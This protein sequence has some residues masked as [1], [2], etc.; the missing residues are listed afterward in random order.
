M[1]TSDIVFPMV[2]G[3]PEV[4]V[5]IS[6]PSAPE[7]NVIFPLASI[8]IF[9]LPK[10]LFVAEIVNVLS[11]EELAVNVK[12]ESFLPSRDNLFV[13]MLTSLPETAVLILTLLLAPLVLILTV[14]ELPL[15]VTP[16]APSSV[17][18]P[19]VVV[20]LE[21]SPASNLIP[22]PVALISTIPDVVIST[23]EAFPAILTPPA[24]S[25]VSAPEVVVKLEASPASNL[26]PA[27]VALISTIPDVVIST[28]EA[29]PAI[30]TP[31]APL[32]V[33][34]PEEV[35]KLE[36]APASNVIPAPV[37]LISTVPDVVISTSA[38]FPAILTP[39]LPSSVNAPEEVVNLEA[40]PASIF[41][42]L[43]ASISMSSAPERVSLP[44]EVVKLEAP[45]ASI[46]TPPVPALI[47]TKTEFNSISVV[48]FIA[49]PNLISDATAS[50]PI[51]ISLLAG[52]FIVIP[53]VPSKLKT[54]DE[55]VKLDP[56]PAI[57]SVPPVP[58]VS[59]NLLFAVILKS[60]VAVEEIVALFVLAFPSN[61]KSPLKAVVS[62]VISIC[63]FVVF[64]IFSVFP[65]VISLPVTVKSPFKTMFLKRAS[66]T[67]PEYTLLLFEA[68]GINVNSLL[69]LSLP[70][71]PRFEVVPSKYLKAIPLS[72]LSVAL[73]D[74]I[75]K[76]GSETVTPPPPP[77]LFV[78]V[79]LPHVKVP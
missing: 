71:K 65:N 13:S 37:E 47:S 20:K 36:A 23:S 42:P 16:P 69:S 53:S 63:P 45:P 27:P 21:A 43:E 15:I 75:I 5:A 1:I 79:K 12:L 19:E 39:P 64:S 50:S 78:I 61:V 3:T 56:P 17:N 8:S 46:V 66:P 59:C 67:V 4:P 30:L 9:A 14:L 74:P 26:I 35:V 22:A 40:A 31:P 51:N 72:W 33:N 10:E 32:S 60:L 18:A 7:S 25:S 57:I 34:A 11:L 73:S 49:F 70:K 58:A 62:A 6:I 44:E 76:T 48:V 29:F 41:T 28:S 55:V 38:A 24:P 2:T 77:P 68:S 54:P 52:T